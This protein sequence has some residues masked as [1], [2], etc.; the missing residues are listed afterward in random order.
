MHK[1]TAISIPLQN[2]TE[3]PQE[4][5][6]TYSNPSVLLGPAT[7]TIPPKSEGGS[8][9]LEF[10][11]APLAP[12]EMDGSVS[13]ISQQLGE[14]WYQMRLVA[15][16]AET[17][18]LPA[19]S[20]E[21]GGRPVRIPLSVTNPLGHTVTLTATA[22][23][24]GGAAPSR[25][26]SVTPASLTLAPWEEGQVVVGY[27]PE[28]VGAQDAARVT[29]AIPG[30]SSWEWDVTGSAGPPGPQEPLSLV[31]HV[32]STAQGAVQWRNPFPGPATVR[33]VLVGPGAD[34]GELAL[35]LALPATAGGGARTGSG[36]GTSGTSASYG[37]TTGSSSSTREVE[38]TAPP[39]GALS[40]PLAFCPRAM[41]AAHAELVVS[42]VPLNAGSSTD[43]STTCSTSQ[44][45]VWRYPVGGIAEAGELPRAAGGAGA[46]PSS[47]S[48]PSAGQPGQQTVFKFR[49]KA[50][51][52]VEEVVEVVLTGLGSVPPEGEVFSHELV[53]PP[54]A[55][56]YITTGPGGIVNVNPVGEPRVTSPGQPLQYA[57]CFAPPRVL[58]PC[59]VELVVSKAS[60]GRWRFELQLVSLEPAVD[61]SIT[62][63]AAMDTTAAE[64]I[65]L[66]APGDEP[67]PFKAWLSGDTPLSFNV[68]PAQGV[69]PVKPPSPSLLPAAEHSGMSSPG[70][71]SPLRRQLSRAGS[72]RRGSSPN[73]ASRSPSTDPLAAAKTRPAVTVT[74]TCRDFGKVVKGRLFVQAGDI[75]YMYDLRGRM[76]NYVPPQ[77]SDYKPTVDTRLSPEVAQRL[78]AASSPARTAG[79]RPNYV[80]TN[81]K[82]TRARGFPS[83]GWGTGTDF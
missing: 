63:E 1:A 77:P 61:G 33:A 46:G 15:T 7:L 11:F 8:A 21:L 26:F 40:F 67:A 65:V 38:R 4:L 35:A 71:S 32:G 53:V 30:A 44:P 13:L 31:S 41:H 43:G 2:P 6:V 39:G 18:V 81:I 20:A 12:G 24:P 28:R 47:S 72:S 25:V 42:A 82:A 55:A 34:S 16:A 70:G 23:E 50:R 52:R 29:I 78:A 10:F 37:G 36:S 69:L 19:V 83:G 14:F 64:S 75:T 45:V 51:T 9:S 57:V 49:C 80:A 5:Q 74:Y 73:A 22:T 17:V 62:L 54:A 56:A 60:G 27:K 3:E 68:H 79:G 76:P 58:P 48:D 66:F 59:T